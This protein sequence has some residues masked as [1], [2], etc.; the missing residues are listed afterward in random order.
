MIR[1]NELTIYEGKPFGN[2]VMNTAYRELTGHGFVP[3]DSVD[4]H[5]SNGIVLEDIPFL[6]GCVLPEGTICLN[7]Y[8]G[9]DW[10]RVEKRFGSV[11]DLCLLTGAETGRIFLNGHGKYKIL[12]E[13]FCMDF[14]TSREMYPNDEFF[15][16]YRSLSGGKI[17]PGNIYRS[18]ASFD[19]IHNDGDYYIR[20]KC[21]DRLMERDGI[22]FVLNMTC[23]REQ[24]EELFSSGKYDGFYIQKLYEEGKAF[25]VQLPSDYPGTEFRNLLAAALRTMIT[26]TGPYLIQCRAGLDRTG[27]LSYLLEALAGADRKETTDDYMRSFECLAG[28]TRDRNRKQYDLLRLCQADRI[29]EI[30]TYGK[31]VQRSLSAI[32]SCGEGILKENEQDPIYA[33]DSLSV[34]AANYLQGCGM[35]P[36]E[37]GEIRQLLVESL[38]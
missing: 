24:A 34:P 19:P 5:F 20:Q 9:F 32:L 17:R 21:L 36:E 30:L 26:H 25:S 2:I 37:I 1:T 31:T 18:T 27:F 3:G 33:A 8:S 11:W 38:L 23:G 35:T 6:S 28:L 13:A 7:A 29:L 16:N 14:A 10:I 15:T 4:V 12:Q 22:Q